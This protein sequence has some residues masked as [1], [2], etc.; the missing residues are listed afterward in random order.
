V[1]KWKG[2]A[3]IP[4]KPFVIWG[5]GSSWTEAQ[6][7]GYGLIYAI[8][9]NFPQAPAIEYHEHDGAGT[10]WDYA[11]DWVKQWVAAEQPDLIFTYTVGTPEGLD[12]MLTEI[13]KHTTA[14]IIVPSIHF[15][16]QSP[17]TPDDIENGYV[18]WEKIREICKKHH[19]EFVEHRREMADYLKATG[20]KPDDLLWDHTH[21]NQHGRIRV[22]DDVMKHITAPAQFS[23]DPKALERDLSIA[24]PTAASTEKVTLSGN[25]TTP[26]G[27]AHSKH[28]GDKITVHF[29]G[30][31]IDLIGRKVAGGGTV[32]VIIDGTPADQAPA[33]YSDY[34]IATPRIYPKKSIKAQP[35]DVAPQ[36]IN[37]GANLVPQSW[38]V[39]M[40][41][42]R[43]N[44]QIEGIVTGPDGNGNVA[45]PFTSKSGQINV[46]PKMWRNGVLRNKD[47]QPTNPPEFGNL[48]GD[49]FA[50]DVRRCAVGRVSFAGDQP[51]PFSLPLVQN[52][53]NQEHTLEIVTNGDG[54]VDIGSF[55]V[56]CPLE[57]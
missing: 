27:S 33:F 37:L 35:G 43:G 13:R 51:K 21:Q 39:T 18:A 10:P 1:A 47:G 2:R 38:T 55:Y 32:K 23:Y 17:M 6:R 3:G 11:G 5:I 52:L 8:R 16:P 22:W 4:G 50:F 30:N 25:W 41:D 12:R 57:K 48:T 28:A 40:T 24:P 19:A 42:D 31:R 44:Y 49:K 20:L 56:F 54:G 7:D 46:D 34:I 29:T 53:P 15:K 14:D 36:A 26:D 9:K 45:Q